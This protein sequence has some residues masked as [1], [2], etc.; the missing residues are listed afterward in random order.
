M[1]ATNRNS[2]RGAVR[3]LTIIGIIVVLAAGAVALGA[4]FTGGKDAQAELANIPTASV[5]QGPLTI[6]V[7]EGGSITAREQVI[8]KSEVE[9]QTTIIQ[10]V[11]EGKQ[12]EVGELLIELDAS[13]LQDNKVEQEIRVQNADA[14]FI[15]ARENLA[16]TQ[17]QA[18]SDIARAE[19]DL[20]FANTDLKKYLE[21][22]YPNQI[23]EAESK[24]TLAKEELERATEKARW[25]EK[26]FE[27]KYISQTEVEG[28]RLAKNRAEL[29][30]ELSVNSLDLLKEFTHGRKLAELKSNVTQSEMALERVNRKATA[31]IVQA[32]AD[33]KAKEAELAQQKSKLEK[34][35]TQISKTKIYAPVA[36][37]VVYATSAQGGWRG[38]DEPLQEGQ[39]VRERQELIFLPT[40]DS[41]MAEIKVHESNL[42]KIELGLPVRVTVDA[43]PGRVFTGAV[44]KIAPLPDATSVWLN[45]DLKVYNTQIALD[46]GQTGLRTG[47]SC[48]AE[49]LVERFDT[50]TYV[51]I[52]SVVRIGKQ[53]HVYTLKNG[54]LE[55]KPVEIGLDNNVNVR[56]VSGLEQGEVVALAPPLTSTSKQENAEAENPAFGKEAE[57][58]AKPA[59]AEA[60]APATES[61]AAPGPAAEAAPA[62]PAAESAAPQQGETAAPAEGAE[63]MRERFQNMS[64]EERQ[65]MRERIQNMSEEERQKLREQ[66][67]GRGTRQ[68]GAPPAGRNQ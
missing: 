10:L 56:I 1:A 19:L 22:E 46:S 66:F 62:Q 39:Q 63:A 36:G 43:L 28:D 38:N 26:L 20:E 4:F 31:D 33:L 12:V 53:P 35:E 41:M 55:P 58:S 27:E 29:E 45:P 8:L 54:K 32:E 15:R 61:G 3:A 52:Q 16:V 2:K 64:E 42:Q 5:R 14:A 67:G 30:H 37:M 23:K 59:A 13:S 65:K 40:A 6:T 17:N 9:G 11:P 18:K 50:A 68:G 47:M 57:G 49:I 24:I 51:P 48:Q 60:T 7:T 44:S 21:G 34:I 25:S